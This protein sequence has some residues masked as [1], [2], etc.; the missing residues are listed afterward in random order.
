MVTVMRTTTV[1]LPLLRSTYHEYALTLLATTTLEAPASRVTCCWPGSQP[2]LTK[3]GAGAPPVTLGTL[4]P[5]NTRSWVVHGLTEVPQP[6]GAG[7]LANTKS[8]SAKAWKVPTW[9]LASIRG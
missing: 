4:L 9:A 1:G 8:S 7:A 5:C 2:Y 6:D 3:Y